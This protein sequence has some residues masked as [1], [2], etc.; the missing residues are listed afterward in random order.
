MIH[1]LKYGFTSKKTG[2]QTTPHKSTS[3][4]GFLDLFEGLTATGTSISRPQQWGP[5]LLLGAHAGCQRHGDPWLDPHRFGRFLRQKHPE[6]QMVWLWECKDPSIPMLFL[7]SLESRFASFCCFFGSDGTSNSLRCLPWTQSAV[8][9][10]LVSGP[11]CSMCHFYEEM[12]K[13]RWSTNSLE[14]SMPLWIFLN[15]FGSLWIRFCSS[16]SPHPPEDHWGMTGVKARAS[17]MRSRSFW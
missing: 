8:K 1:I 3:F 15:L 6:I 9:R 10:E 4:H 5:S 14:K 17:R 11:S 16:A 7:E 2:L 12:L 13:L